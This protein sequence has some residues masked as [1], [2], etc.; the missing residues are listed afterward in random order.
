LSKTILNFC[1]SDHPTKNMVPTQK[2]LHCMANGRG[3]GSL[4]VYKS[5]SALVKEHLRQLK[6]LQTTSVSSNPVVV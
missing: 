5:F 2:Y 1:K 3:Q 4:N 6:W